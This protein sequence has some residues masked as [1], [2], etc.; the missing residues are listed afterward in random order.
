ME[1]AVF[2]LLHFLHLLTEM[3]SGRE[4]LDLLR[5]TLDQFQRADG[6]E[7]GD[8]VDR[9]VR[10]QL[11]ALAADNRQRVDDVGAQVQQTQLE[12]LEQ[13][14]GARADDDHISLDH[15]CLT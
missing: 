4:R 11:G 14:A 3:E 5:Q 1:A 2:Q 7:P 9:L 6:G 8:V 15:D 12:Y 10:I 13:A